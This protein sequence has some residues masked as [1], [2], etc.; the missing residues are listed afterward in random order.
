V[1]PFSTPTFVSFNHAIAF[2]ATKAASVD[3]SPAFTWAQ[4]LL[5]S[6]ECCHAA[7]IA[8]VAVTAGFVLLWSGFGLKMCVMIC[9]PSS[10]SK[11]ASGVKSVKATLVPVGTQ[12]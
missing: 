9:S 1:V 10:S 7:R 4:T 8:P 3:E 5:P 6:R 11:V 2:G 12:T